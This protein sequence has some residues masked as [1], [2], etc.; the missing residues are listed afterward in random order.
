MASIDF[1]YYSLG[2]GFIL[3]VIEAGFTAYHLVLTL[4]AMR[5]LIEKTDDILSD[6]QSIKNTVKIGVFGAVTQFI[7]KTL[8]KGR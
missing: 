8:K 4:A 2:I 3:L 6:V 1:L 5:K 7:A